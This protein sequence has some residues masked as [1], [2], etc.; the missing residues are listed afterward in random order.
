MLDLLVPFCLSGQGYMTQAGD[1]FPL[2]Y[3]FI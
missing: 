2:R 3:K 1:L